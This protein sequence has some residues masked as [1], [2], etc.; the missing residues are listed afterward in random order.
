MQQFRSRH[1]EKAR[2]YQ[3]DFNLERRKR[4]LQHYGGHCECCGEKQFEF[5]A[6][7][8]KDGG[9]NAH[10]KE[11]KQRG[12]NMIGWVIQNNFPPMFRVLCHNCNSAIGFYG[13]CPHQAAQ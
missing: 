5:L 4:V 7:D 1:G 13:S 10:R 12:A 9:G 6:L 11:V 3:R 8:H 2:A